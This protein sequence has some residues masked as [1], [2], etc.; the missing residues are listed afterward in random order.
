M[1]IGDLVTNNILTRV[2]L[3]VIIYLL[4]LINQPMILHVHG[5]GTLIFDGVIKNACG[6]GFVTMYWIWWLRVGPF[7]V[8][9]CGLECQFGN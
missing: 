3:D 6:G 7:S 5:A 1:V 9:F 4:N 8:A 2:P